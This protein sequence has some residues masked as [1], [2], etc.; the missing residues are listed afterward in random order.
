MSI[1]DINDVAHQII[2]G[3][4]DLCR[5]LLARP[6][7]YTLIFGAGIAVFLSAIAFVVSKIF[8]NAA[9]L[10][11]SFGKFQ[12]I[13]TSA[14]HLDLW[15]AR[16]MGLVVSSKFRR[17]IL[18]TVTVTSIGV[19]AYAPPWVAIGALIFGVLVSIVLY[20]LWSSDEED[21]ARGLQADRKRVKISKD[22]TSDV[23]RSAFS[24]IVIFPL[25]F[26][27]INALTENESLSIPG[28]YF[29]GVGYIDYVVAEIVRITPVVGNI[30][31][32]DGIPFANI[33][34]HMWEGKLTSFI[35]RAMGEF[36]LIAVIFKAVKIVVRVRNGED[37]RRQY[38]KM[39][40]GNSKRVLK[41]IEELRDF[42]VRGNLNALNEMVR[43]ADPPKGVS[44]KI[45]NFR[46]DA[47]RALFDLVEVVP[48][49]GFTLLNVVIASY[50]HY[51]SDMEQAGN[52]LE[53]ANGQ[54]ALGRA[55][56]SRGQYMGDDRAI[57]D[58]EAS[59]AAY[60]EALTVLTF[61]AFPQEWAKV[62]HR[63]GFGLW[64][65]GQR[66]LGQAA[67]TRFQ[68]AETACREALKVRRRDTL[69]WAETQNYIGLILWRHGARVPGE[70]GLSLLK[71]GEDAY[72]EALTVRTE[73]ADKE[74]WAETRNN[75]GLL[76]LNQ[77]ER[78]SGA[79]RKD[80]LLEAKA[81]FED[82]F[83]YRTQETASMDWARTKTNRASVLSRLARGETDE[84]ER[85]SRLD[86]AERAC[87][88]AL[89]VFTQQAVPVHWARIMTT[90][91]TIYRIRSE[92]LE[93]APSVE[94]LDKAGAAC[95]CAL[96]VFTRQAMP[97]D[98]A[99]TMVNMGETLTR[100]ANVLGQ[101]YGGDKLTAAEN[102]LEDALTIL[103]EADMP[104]DYAK[105]ARCL[106]EVLALRAAWAGSPEFA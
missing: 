76:L 57:D 72:L 40:S 12:H 85:N 25:L 7:T 66:L 99:Q 93:G 60:R 38:E 67:I 84:T 53:W 52:R 96:E 26:F 92:G 22:L 97:I 98:W 14:D 78:F 6:V 37:L 58:L 101:D 11:R 50:E 94:L 81:C 104:L 63:L 86:H 3:L 39:E 9:V 31:I 19:G 90:Q 17:A 79:K 88:D 49:S 73:N 64:R 1:H 36:L 68:Q 77:A 29:K 82:A 43:V 83:R 27:Q 41:A 15:A 13:V 18:F 44:G 56:C 33:A 46:M 102:A 54:F 75:L 34:P 48:N 69:E 28:E 70:P 2:D 32:F 95:R 89:L 47:A 103:T 105:A 51:I 106:E 45:L 21:R 100:H 4:F 8:Q 62:Q 59:L 35:F 80:V 16:L 55:L 5:G 65:L 87:Q 24:L 91:A 23:W 42:I 74:K 30:E 20:R 71:R 61:E 10:K